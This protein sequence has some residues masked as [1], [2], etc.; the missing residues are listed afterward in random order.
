M[1]PTQLL[2]TR[3]LDPLCSGRLGIVEAGGGYGKSVLG[4]QL[5]SRLG[6]P[7]ARL[8]LRPRDADP[9]QFPVSLLQS[10]RAARL[11]DLAASLDG[12]AEVSAAVGSF[13]QAL[14]VTQEPVLVLVDDAHYLQGAASAAL[15]RLFD[16]LP[17]PHRILVLGRSVPLSARRAGDGAGVTRLSGDD[18]S[19]SPE[20]IERYLFDVGGLRIS[21]FAIATIRRATGGWPAA[22]ALWAKALASSGDAEATVETLAAQRAGLGRLVESLLGNLNPGEVD[23]AYQL[24]HLPLLSPEATAAITGLPD[25][26]SG[27]EEAGLPLVEAGRGWA[28]I[29]DPVA[30]HLMGKR[31]LAAAVARRAGQVYERNGED[32]AA[33]STLLAAGLGAEAADVIARLSPLRRS[34]VGAAGLRAYVAEL[35]D[36]V[37]SER[38]EVWLQS[39]RASDSDGHW[40]DRTHALQRAEEAAQSGGDL[41]RGRPLLHEIRAEQAFDHLREGRLDEAGRLAEVILAESGEGEHGARSR[42]LACAGRLKALR[43]R[44]DEAFE[45]AT[46]L[47]QRAAASAR[48]AGDDR[49]TAGVLL[50]LAE[51]ALR[52]RCQYGDALAAIEEALHLLAGSAR[53]RALALSS[54][55]DTLL[56]MG[57]V[58]E[59]EAGIAESMHLGRIMHDSAVIAYAAWTEIELAVI[60]GDQRRLTSAIENCEQHRHDWFSGFS[61]LGFLTDAADALDRLALHDAAAGYLERARSRRHQDERQFAVAEACIAARS[62]DPARGRL[63]IR[64]ALDHPGLSPRRRWRLQLLD[65]WAA[66]ASGDE[67]AGRLAAQ[68]FDSCLDLGWPQ[69][70]LVREQAVAEALLPLALA[71]GSYSARGL[72]ETSR[73]MRL[74]CLG[75]VVLTRR[76]HVLE[77]PSGR[78]T[79]AVMAVVATGGS[80]HAEQLIDLLWP[81]ADL[82]VGR[83]RLRNVLSRVKG[84]ADGLLERQGDVVRL[85]SEVEVDLTEFEAGARQALALEPTDADR[86]GAVARDA[87]ALYRGPAFRDARYESWA[88]SARE[89]ARSLYLRLLDLLARDAERHE[90]V[91]EAVRLLEQAIEVEPYDEDRYA[92]AANLL[93]SQGRIGSA[94]TMLQRCRSA[95]EELGM[96]PTLAEWEGWAQGR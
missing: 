8:S 58:D 36:A 38:P 42:A 57:R 19:F 52:E 80:M 48:R 2:R 71:A 63:L 69:L 50:R 39:A 49:W 74:R 32:G 95:L 12:R 82:D 21:D 92:K 20:E 67:R 51:D 60:V 45:E 18:L 70:P 9:A 94:R 28:R 59:A 10:L 47:L 4:E 29:A 83:G 17:A 65:A 23:M 44:S 73:V 66:F 27:I 24:A 13:L 33:I 56:E 7:T 37:L 16:E 26:Y 87:A 81:E 72:S 85:A 5:S 31:P 41:G 3:L 35:P 79:L 86:A 46:R 40:A 43:A 68:V 90:Q 30:E 84:A 77:L 34:G 22:V 96:E 76:G 1:A 61:G 55:C 25:L 15:D 64:Q 6:A 88:V 11:S 93:R 53:G 78:P 91:D 14:A 75:E 62:G 54:R 89:R